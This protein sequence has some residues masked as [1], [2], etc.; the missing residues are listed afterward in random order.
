[1][2]KALLGLAVLLTATGCTAAARARPTPLRAQS[3]AQMDEDRARCE[4][5]AKLTASVKVGYAACMVAAGYEAVPEVRSTSQRVRLTRTPAADEPIRVLVD[6]MACDDDAQREVERGFGMVRRFIRDFTGW[7]MWINTTRRR[8]LF[9]D[10]LRPRG[11]EI[12][13]S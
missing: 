13:Q 1:V 4:K 3:V 8:Q 6:F 10:C 7:S 12:V 5:W 11:Y 2:L 9:V